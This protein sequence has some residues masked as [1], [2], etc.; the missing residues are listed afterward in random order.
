[1]SALDRKMLRDLARL[2]SQG[3][4]IALVLAAGVATLVLAIGA[5]RSLSGTRTAYYERS[6]F[7]DVFAGATRVP[8]EAVGRLREIPG[9]AA[10]EPRVSAMALLDIPGQDAPATGV[11]QSL[12]ED[13]APRLNALHLRAGRLPDPLHPDEVAAN[14]AFALAHR[15]RPGDRL[16]AI[17]DGRRRELTITG[18]VLSPEFVYAIGPGDLMPDDSRFGTFAMGY[19]PLAGAFDLDGAYNQVSL[20][21]RRD[22]DEAA[23]I[24]AVDAILA[25][26]GGNGAYGRADQTS[27]AFL[28]AELDQLRALRFVIPPIFLAVAAFLVN[29]T[30]ARLIALEREQIGLMKAL[31]YSTAA[32]ALHYLKLAALIAVL[33]VLI[34]WGAGTWLG[35]GLTGIYNESFRFPFLLFRTGPDIYAISG[36]IGLGATLLGALHAIARAVALPPAVAM[37]PPQP[38]AYRHLLSERLGLLAHAPQALTM[39]LRNIVRWPLRSGLTVLGLALSIAILVGS[40]FAR[41]AIER[42]V[43]ATF[44]AAHRPDASLILSDIRPLRAVEAAARLPG[45]LAVEPSRTVPVRLSHGHREKRVGLTGMPAD[46]DWSRVV[47]A[48]LMPVPL[49]ERGIA[50]DASL[51][52]RLGVQA[53]DTVAA[54]ILAGRRETVVLPVT[55][56]IEQLVGLGAY[57]RLEALNALMRDGSVVDSLHLA[58][59]GDA[60]D[61]LYAAVK[62]TPAV[63]GLA[64][65]QRSLASFRR[66]MATNIRI[67]VIV[68]TTLASVVGFGVT[69]NSVRIRLSERARELASLRVLGFSRAEVSAMLLLEL[70]ILGA[71]AIPLGWLLGHAL[72]WAVTRGLQ[73]DI[74]RVPLL[75]ERTTYGYATLV[76]LVVAALSALIVRRRIDRLDMVEV[77][78]TRE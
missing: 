48:D 4:A 27:H 57:M 64:L 37:A 8:A 69:Y 16:T 62:Q 52:R 34:G 68:Y 28:E 73:G 23:V 7:A 13:G 26:Y 10:V 38:P 20:E 44:F 65:R 59:D 17:L 21:L 30:M 66:T 49:P 47:D 36:A 50:L 11:F 77:L 58:V 45:V 76:F 71:A 22:A 40:L 6:R 2:W 14:E 75:I 56:I 41:D 1:M 63:A 60:L 12:P 29:M 9:V 18:L 31:G 25:P 39:G 42:M 51:A 32:V 3:L 15:F 61:G 70:A 33:G 46:G 55:A 53:G 78:K 54:E 43:E 19:A 72:A 35:R 24:D 5:E 74:Y 67:M